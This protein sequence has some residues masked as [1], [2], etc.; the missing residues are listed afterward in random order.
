MRTKA[1]AELQTTL[2][3]RIQSAHD[4][5]SRFVSELETRVQQVC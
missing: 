3:K 5:A 4:D 1:H 2:E